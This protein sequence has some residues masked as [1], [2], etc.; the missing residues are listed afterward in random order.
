[1]KQ[2]FDYFDTAMATEL[3]QVRL[4]S[5]P[6]FPDGIGLIELSFRGGKV[7]IAVE[8]EFDT[9]LCSRAFPVAYLSY[10]YLGQSSFWDSFVG[11]SLVG[12][13]QMTNDRGY[14]DAIQLRFREIPNA[15]TYAVVQMYGEASQITLVE[16]AQVR[17]VSIRI[18]GRTM[19]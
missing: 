15:G 16:T 14:P 11:K 5:H 9:L 18:S 17:E 10:T 3:E 19:S 1:M 12:A 6:D 4:F 2:E 7:F 13:W 8:D